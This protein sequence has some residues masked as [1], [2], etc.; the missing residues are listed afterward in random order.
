VVDGMC[1]VFSRVT[2]NYLTLCEMSWDKKSVALDL[3][4]DKKSSLHHSQKKNKKE[5]P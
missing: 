2:L 3:D 5:T 4:L 1:I